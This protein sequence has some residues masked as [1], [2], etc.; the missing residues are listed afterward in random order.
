MF[1]ELLAYYLTYFQQ[2]G[3]AALKTICNCVVPSKIILE[4]YKKLP[5]IESMAEKEKTEMKKYVIENFPDRTKEQ[6]VEICKIVYTIGTL[7]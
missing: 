7:L 5:P 3:E 2:H 6:Q 4:A 1:K